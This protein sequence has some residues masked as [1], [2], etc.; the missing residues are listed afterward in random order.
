MSHKLKH[1]IQGSGLMAFAYFI[2]RFLGLLREMSIAHQF[3]AGKLTDIY[4]ASFLIPDVLNYMLAGGAFSIVLIPMLSKYVTD[5]TPPQLTTKGKEIFTAIF[6]PITTGLIGLTIISI[7]LTPAISRLIYPD[8]AKNNVQFDLLVRLTRLILPA[9]VFFMA[10]GLINATLRARGDFRG[11]A[12][13]PNIYNLGIILGVLFLGRSMGVQGA[14]LG[15]LAGAFVGPFLMC[16]LLAG[17]TIPYTFNLNFKSPPF[18]EYIKLNLPL[19]IGISLLTVDQFFIR[20]FGAQTGVTPG[21][22][23]CLNYSRTIM[24]VPI[25]LVGQAVGQVSLTY[26]AQLWQSG[27]I[28]EF[29]ITLSHTIRGVVFL[30]FIVSGLIF[31]LAQPIINILLV[32]GKFT[33]TNSHYTTELLRYMIMAVPPFAALQILVNGYYAKK[34]TLR[35]MV[36][37]SICTIISAIVYYLLSFHMKGPGIAIA[38]AICFWIIFLATLWDYT[39]RYRKVEDVMIRKLTGTMLKSFLVTLFGVVVCFILFEN[40]GIINFNPDIKLSAFIRIILEGGVFSGCSLGATLLLGG[41][42]ADI[43]QKLIKKIFNKILR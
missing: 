7:I 33:I 13:G 39:R 27:K 2:S 37:S 11:N 10:G 8:F 34:N 21:T 26:L 12:W 42:E 18:I 38:S 15:V 24:L 36:V 20:Y 43:I 41:E 9:Q 3:G 40:P 19:M 28:K 16:A 35:P 22:I 29:S 23:T 17:N 14:S 30:S 1:I 25:T 6:T 5:T 31:L 4:N 32:R